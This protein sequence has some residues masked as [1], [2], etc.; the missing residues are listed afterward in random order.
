VSIILTPAQAVALAGIVGDA[1]GPLQLHQVG[2]D[3]DILITWGGVARPRL[4]MR[5]DG[6]TEP[7]ADRH[8]SDAGRARPE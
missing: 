7:V 3:P 6:T 1:Q 8:G 5:P 2:E 4:L